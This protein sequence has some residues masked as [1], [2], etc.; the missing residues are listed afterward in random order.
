MRHTFTKKK[1]KKAH[2]VSSKGSYF[3]F[4]NLATIFPVEL[5]L[6]L[7]VGVLRAAPHPWIRVTSFLTSFLPNLPLPQPWPSILRKITHMQAFVS[8][9][10]IWESQAKKIWSSVDDSSLG[11]K[12]I[13]SSALRKTGFIITWY[14][15]SNPHVIYS[16]WLL[17]SG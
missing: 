12:Y 3:Y 11:C 17:K 6:S 13:D 4:L 15:L 1:K 8:G 16:S 5:R 9:S 2:S 7:S 10:I 14:F